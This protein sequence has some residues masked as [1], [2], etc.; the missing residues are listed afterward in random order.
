MLSFSK[1]VHEFRPFYRITYNQMLKIAEAINNSFPPE[2]KILVEMEATLEPENL[3]HSMRLQKA[4]EGP[5]DFWL[6]FAT[7]SFVIP[8]D[9]VKPEG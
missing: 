7:T 3:Q 1:N 9:F 6:Y 4:A 5:F 8:V 2:T